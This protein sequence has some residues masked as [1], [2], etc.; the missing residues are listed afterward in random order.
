MQ[1]DDLDRVHGQYDVDGVDMD[2]MTQRMKPIYDQRRRKTPHQAIGV[3]DGDGDGGAI[4]SVPNPKSHSTPF[5]RG[6]PIHTSLVRWSHS[7]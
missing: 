5:Y 4:P 7:N 3:G 1:M 2:S 6:G